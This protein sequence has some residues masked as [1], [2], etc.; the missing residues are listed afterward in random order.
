MP[1]KVLFELYT[2]GFFISSF[3]PGVVGGDVARWH[4]AGRG[5]EERMK[6]AATIL[7]ERVTGMAAL[8]LMCLLA[9]I[10]DSTRFATPPVLALLVA[11]SVTLIVSLTLALNRR[12]ATGLMYQT[13]RLAISRFIQ[14]LYQLQR[15]LRCFT[16]QSLVVAMC[17][18][19]L[20]YL[21]AGSTFFLICQAFGSHITFLEAISVQILTC[22][23]IIIPISLGGLGLAQV[24][25]VY[26][27]GMLGTDAATALGISV[28]R[29]MIKYGYALIGGIVLIRWQYH[30]RIEGT[31]DLRSG[32]ARPDNLSMVTGRR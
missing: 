18:S 29:Q 1:R 25:D 5:V 22:L 23:L 19:C 27:L 6:V 10:W 26:L 32:K 15:S 4:M 14:P 20:F 28:V 12:L 21:A 7:V 9:V 31:E 3:L 17:Y 13:R 8:I 11:M 2:I 30:P 16:R 24:G